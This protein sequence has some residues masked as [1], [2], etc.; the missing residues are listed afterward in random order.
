M[1]PRPSLSTTVLVTVLALGG[2][3]DSP[4]PG[5]DAGGDSAV[6]DLAAEPGRDLSPD[7]RGDLVPC[8]LIKP[9]SSKN[10]TCNQC[11]E[12]KCCVEINGCLADPECD[13]SY[14]N[15]TLACALGPA[16]DAGMSACLGQCGT[17]YPKGKSEYEAA[18]GCADTRC[19]SECQ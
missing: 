17:A 6:R 5:R 11:A 14:V 9:Y 18:T 12:N 8:K 1:T 3:S 15:C 2:C 16:P 10:A 4:P 13:D 19:A 7:R